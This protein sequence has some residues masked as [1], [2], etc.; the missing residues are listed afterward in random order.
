MRRARDYILIVLII[1][2]IMVISI[3]G[4]VIELAPTIFLLNNL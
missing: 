3:V 2:A 1:A 4:K